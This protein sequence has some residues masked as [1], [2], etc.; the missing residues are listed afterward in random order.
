[1]YAMHFY[2]QDPLFH[3]HNITW[4]YS[5]LLCISVSFYFKWNYIL[6]KRSPVLQCTD[7]AT[8]TCPRETE[9]ER[10]GARERQLW[11]TDHMCDRG[12]NILCPYVA[13]TNNR[14]RNR[15]AKTKTSKTRRRTY[16]R[17]CA[18]ER[19]F[20]TEKPKKNK[21]NIIRKAEKETEKARQQSRKSC[22]MNFNSS[23]GLLA[24][25]LPFCRGLLGALIYFLFLV[26]FA[27]ALCW[28]CKYFDSLFDRQV[29]AGPK[30]GI[31]GHIG[32]E[33]G[34]QS[35]SDI[36]H[37]IEPE[38]GHGA[39]GCKQLNRLPLGKMFP[40]PYYKAA[41][42]ALFFF[43]IKMFTHSFLI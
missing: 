19:I 5:F 36:S 8:D 39:G 26:W 21:E 27:V 33:E 20:Y 31:H 41:L 16:R 11:P 34:G 13:Q 10:E 18:N 32:G 1:M 15:E 43:V 6:Y 40:N 24:G 38:K 12:S 2:Q 29:A 3:S 14:N 35:V 23:A 22:E 9:W 28:W 17:E 4:L 7:S 25:W 30:R 42:I 37:K